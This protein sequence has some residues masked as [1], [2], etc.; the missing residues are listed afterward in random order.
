MF[1]FISINML[2]LIL[3]VYLTSALRTSIASARAENVHKS[4]EQRAH[5][6]PTRALGDIPSQWERAVVLFQKQLRGPW[7]VRAVTRAG[8]FGEQQEEEEKRWCQ[9]TK[10]E[11]ETHI[12]FLETRGLS[13]LSEEDFRLTTFFCIRQPSDRYQRLTF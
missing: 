5:T 3:N 12:F 1:M 6:R 2:M 8:Y 9:L 11:T 10:R 7:V 13:R 4:R